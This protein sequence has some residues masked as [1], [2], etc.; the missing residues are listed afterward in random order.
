M[1]KNGKRSMIASLL[2]AAARAE[3][4]QGLRLPSIGSCGV[5]IAVAVNRRETTTVTDERIM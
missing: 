2:A 4:Q 5:L 1:A 3:L